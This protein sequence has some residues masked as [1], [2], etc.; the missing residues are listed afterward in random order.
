[1]TKISASSRSVGATSEKI[2]NRSDH[3]TPGAGIRIHCAAS[4]CVLPLAAEMRS[5][6]ADTRRHDRIGTATSLAN[7]RGQNW[8]SRP[9]NTSADASVGPSGAREIPARIVGRA[10]SIGTFR[11][12]EG[13]GAT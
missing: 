8:T 11:S 10:G 6:W 7:T 9:R 13:G 12:I 1:M 5:G 3:L 2:S 4:G